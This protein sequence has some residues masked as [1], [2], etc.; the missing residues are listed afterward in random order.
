MHAVASRR[1]LS[2]VAALAAAALLAFWALESAA[3][4][5]P[6]DAESGQLTGAP[7]GSEAP[8]VAD[9]SERELTAIGASGIYSAPTGSELVFELTAVT[10]SG[11]TLA[12]AEQ[13]STQGM[14]LQL[15]GRL[16][17][18][19]AD[20]RGDELVTQ[21]RFAELTVS[22]IVG[23]N[24][25]PNARLADL[26]TLPVLVRMRD[27]GTLLGFTFDPAS[28]PFVNNLVR[29]VL[30]GFRFVVP[31]ERQPTWT[32]DETD[33]TGIAAMLYTETG[34]AEEGRLHLTRR[35]TSYRASPGAAGGLPVAYD[36]D[37]TATATL[38]LELGW[39]REARADETLQA[40]AETAS[41]H[42]TTS[43]RATLALLRHALRGRAELPAVDWDGAWSDIGGLR[44]TQ[45]LAAANA[46]E[47]AAQEVG[48]ATFQGLWQEIQ[49]LAA[50]EPL[51]SAALSAAMH[52]LALLV[53]LQPEVLPQLLAALPAATEFG[54]DALL[55]AVGAADSGPAQQVLAGVTADAAAAP[56]L[57]QSALDS[58]IQLSAP[59]DD[60]LAAVR[61]VVDDDH[62]KPSLRDNGLL[63]LGALASRE[64]GSKTTDRGQLVRDLLARESQA[65]AQRRLEHWLHALG[66]CGDPAVLPALERYLVHQDAALRQAAL[67]AVSQVSAA[68][69]VELLAWRAREEV[70]LRLR[71]LAVQSLAR[72]ATGSHL[73]FVAGL[74]A[75]PGAAELRRAAVNGLRWQVGRNDAV[76]PLLRRAAQTD[77]DATVRDLAQRALAGG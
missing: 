69:A 52:R 12:I 72:V 22:Q 70:E 63:L 57:R 6:R 48:D 3:P 44:D 15:R 65:R 37:S 77:P 71:A 73:E 45:A 16:E 19:V 51:D 47:L 53:R 41:M 2:A 32:L 35:K 31:A 1:A 49:A 27:D 50:A 5:A 58:M 36:V 67:T 13:P 20:R 24:E 26:L 75:G 62:A 7:A 8:A 17:L 40:R 14:T 60:V 4:V 21:A 39:L 25:E 66:N 33:P 28:N 59:G 18:L 56:H 55:S 76:L 30:C 42:A 10:R 9:Q 74:L 11:L 54:A 34:R 38:D 68:R 43:Y 29:T 46:E 61:G 23:G 64:P